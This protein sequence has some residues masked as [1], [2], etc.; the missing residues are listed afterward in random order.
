[1]I[2]QKE[3]KS[4]TEI[5]TSTMRIIAFGELLAEKVSQR[6]VPS[7]FSSDLSMMVLEMLT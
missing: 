5:K 6:D 7:V 2:I 1:M 3:T 4:N